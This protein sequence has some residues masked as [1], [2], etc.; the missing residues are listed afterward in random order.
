MPEP[1][2]TA[3]YTRKAIYR[4]KHLSSCASL[5]RSAVDCGRRYLS[6]PAENSKRKKNKSYFCLSGSVILLTMSAPPE[7]LL[8]C[9]C[10]MSACVVASDLMIQSI[11]IQCFACLI[12]KFFQVL[13]R[14]QAG[15]SRLLWSVRSLPPLLPCQCACSHFVRAKS[16]KHRERSWCKGETW[17]T[18]MATP[19]SDYLVPLGPSQVSPCRMAQSSLVR[20][21]RIRS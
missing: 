15:L 16:H 19:D 12:C 5:L 7:D 2:L 10:A 1:L 21:P 8:R 14:S 4:L 13:G 17:S 18:R 9:F 6:S 11:R 3:T 20:L